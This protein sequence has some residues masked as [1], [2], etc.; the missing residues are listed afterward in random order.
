MIIISVVSVALVIFLLVV[1]FRAKA[2]KK[3]NQ[4]PMPGR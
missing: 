1:V 3:D 4:G 2:K